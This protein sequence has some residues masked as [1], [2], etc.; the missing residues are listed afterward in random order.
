MNMEFTKKE[1]CQYGQICNL[2][3]HNRRVI[4]PDIQTKLEERKRIIERTI[5][6]TCGRIDMRMYSNVS[7]YILKGLSMKEVGLRN[8][9]DKSTVSRDVTRFF[10]TCSWAFEDITK[11]TG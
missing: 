5:E 8:H 3:A 2:L 4:N 10:A 1:F 6:A 11:D 9:C 7:M